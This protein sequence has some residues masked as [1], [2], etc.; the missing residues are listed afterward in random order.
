MI[1]EEE[2]IIKND[3]NIGATIAYQD[4]NIKRPLILLIMGTG[5]LDRNGNGFGFKSNIYKELSDM[6]V[7]I[8][9]KNSLVWRRKWQPSPVFLPGKSHAQRS[10]VGYSPWG[11]RESDTT[12]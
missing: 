4:K 6:F 1:N 11:C 10:L 9:L 8:M 12:E 2:V 3:I 5:S 7:E